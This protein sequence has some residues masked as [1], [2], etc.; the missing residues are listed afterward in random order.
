MEYL[1]IR[2]EID[3]PVARLVVAPP[4]ASNRVGARLLRELNDACD[5]IAND[6][7]V[8]VLIL[9]ADGEDFCAGW[10]PETAAEGFELP[11]D[12]FGCLQAAPQ[13]VV[14]AV[15]GRAWS[16]GFE[17]ALAAD[18]RI[19]SADA[20]FAMPETEFGGLP[21]AGGGQ[22]LARLAGRATALAMLLTGEELDAQAAYR[23]GLVSKVTDRA[24]LMAQAEATARSIAEKGPIAT[25]Y[26]KEAIHRGL[27]MPLDQALR[28][29]TDLTI[30]LQTTS[31]R[32]EGVRAFVDKRKPEFKGR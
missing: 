22:R 2:L 17:L 19:C 1:A 13:P 24:G 18:V 29:E 11:F 28:Y 32:A 26:A 12:A 15:Q 6:D 9:S 31:D 16:A 20:R 8:R 10:A 23:A 30:I 14:C 3:G 5:T 27:D 4:D 21:R 7:G 25:R